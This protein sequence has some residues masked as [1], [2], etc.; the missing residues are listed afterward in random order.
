M[1]LECAEAG[2][3]LSPACAD[4][5][6][7][8]TITKMAFDGY[9]LRPLR[10][11]LFSKIAGG[12]AQAG[13]GLDLSLI[14]QLLGDKQMGLSVQAE[15]LNLLEEIRRRR[16]LTYL[17]VSHDLAIIT[18]MCGRLMVMQSGEAVEHLQASDLAGHR[19]E[20]AYTRNLLKASEGFDRATQGR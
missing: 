3:P 14:A 4:R 19:V 5:I 16:Q 1:K 12:T 8:A 17:M 11:E 18:H 9:D 20:K 15:V 6:G 10:D 2:N 7:F 13:D